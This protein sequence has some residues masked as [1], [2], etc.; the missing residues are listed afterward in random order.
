[1]IEAAAAE[2]VWI[3][4]QLRFRL[5]AVVRHF[6]MTDARGGQDDVQDGKNL[7]GF[8]GSRIQKKMTLFFLLKVSPLLL[9]L[10][11]SLSH[12]D[13]QKSRLVLLKFFAAE[14][15]REVTEMAFSERS[16]V[17]E[18]TAQT[19]PTSD[20]F[21]MFS[22]FFSKARA[23]DRLHYFATRARAFSSRQSRSAET[24]T[25]TETRREEK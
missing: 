5:V 18:E 19:Q 24:E 15:E 20:H 21:F 23:L 7:D 1:M 16:S 3:G 17:C 9:L 11:E 8:G 4:W 12:R 22:L 6:L 10:L 14:R 25:E 13:W 2:A